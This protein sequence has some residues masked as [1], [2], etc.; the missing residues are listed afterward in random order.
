MSTK[1]VVC[2]GGGPAGLFLARLIRLLEP[3][4]NVTVYERNQA[5]ATVGFGIG[6]GDQTM[7]NLAAIDPDTHRR[8]AECGVVGNGMELRHR[9]TTIRWGEPGGTA[10]A[11][12]TL[13]T[14]LRGQAADVGARIVFDRQLQLSE[15]DSATVVVGAD[16]VHSG[17]RTALRQE[18]GVQERTGSGMYIWLGADL[19]LDAMTFSFVENEHG[20]WA[21]HAYPYAPGSATF[22]VETDEGSWRNAGLDAF[23]A[24]SGSDEVSRRYLEQVF[25]A[26][27]GGGRLLTNNSRWSRFR[28]IRCRRWSA[29]NV[30]LLGDSAHTA[31]FSVGS[32]TTLALEDAIA[33]ATEL[34]SQSDVDE[35]LRRFEEKRR[36]IVERLQMRAEASQLWWETM[37]QR[38]DCDAEE[39]AFHYLTRTGA[40]SFDRVRAGYPAFADTVRARFD[41]AVAET[42]GI[43]TEAEDPLYT[44]VRLR[45]DVLPSRVV[46]TKPPLPV[47]RA[48][49]RDSRLTFFGGL[50]LCGAGAV[51][52]DLCD[53]SEGRDTTAWR[54]I[55]R[56]VSSLTSA[57]LGVRVGVDDLDAPDLVAKGEFRL[58]E[59]DLS[60]TP[61]DPD[62]LR[63][64]GDLVALLRKDSEHLRLVAADLG[65]PQ[66]APYGAGAETLVHALAAL[67]ETG[68]DLVRLRAAGDHAAAQ[69]ATVQLAEQIRRHTGLR[70]ITGGRPF[71][72]EHLRTEVLAGRIDFAECW[73]VTL[74]QLRPAEALS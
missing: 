27:L 53:T 37:G 38:L 42:T 41:D 68:L 58:A 57:V 63:R 44:P 4:W 13:L 52:V 23:D 49:D 39:L 17:T 70:I 15:V 32:G 19:D 45:D 5:D 59:I 50:A 48:D 24:S 11:R 28:N 10:I 47:G 54:D 14:T 61:T 66:V 51:V 60:A 21:A 56:L 43:D 35:A 7:A 71:T 6:L 55:N 69:V 33:L 72:T 73:P 20:S 67:A 25:H 62:A 8:L 3:S 12:Q 64:L 29:G 9:G 74:P 2:L 26:D 31:H 30:V 22:L 40:L 16:G 46:V 18:F 36:P 1:S 65:A 34:V